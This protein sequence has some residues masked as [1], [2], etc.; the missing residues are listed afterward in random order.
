MMNI[1]A[2][3]GQK[4]RYTCRGGYEEQRAHIE[5]LGVR[6]GDVLTVFFTQV[7]RGSTGVVFEEIEGIHNSAMFDHFRENVDNTEV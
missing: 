7:G 5:S 6:A 1:Y 3:A 2:K 4:V